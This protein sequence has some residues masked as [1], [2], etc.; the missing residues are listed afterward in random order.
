[1]Y[2]TFDKI[3][4]E[5]YIKDAQND[6]DAETAKNEWSQLVTPVRSTENSA[7]YD[8]YMPYDLNVRAGEEYVVKTGI[9]CLLA[10][11]KFLAVVP[12]SGLGFKYG[13]RLINTIGIIDADYYDAD[14]YGH[15]MVSFTA[16]EDF[17]LHTGDRFCQGIILPYFTVTDDCPATKNRTGGMGST[18]A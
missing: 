5:Q 18:G 17:E 15:I 14:N 3:P 7:G 4:L 11:D 1:M 13:M 6:V 16:D 2:M 10:P 9:C 12:R 8:F